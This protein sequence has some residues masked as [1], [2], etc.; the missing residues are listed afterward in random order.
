MRLLPRV[1]CSLPRACFGHRRYRNNRHHES[2]KRGIF[3][4]TSRRH[5][6]LHQAFEH[7]EDLAG[8]GSLHTVGPIMRAPRAPSSDNFSWQSSRPPNCTR[9]RDR[10]R[11]P[12]AYGAASCNVAQPRQTP[13]PKH[14]RSSPREAQATAPQSAAAAVLHNLRR[15]P[16][17]LF[18]LLEHDQAGCP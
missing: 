6:S 10:C 5:N 18:R 8:G 7:G 17:G 9:R 12:V 1:C 2:N 3:L 14:M 4:G 11:A 13:E 16:A 15:R